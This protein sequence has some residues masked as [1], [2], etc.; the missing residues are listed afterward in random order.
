MR[1][2]LSR[3]CYDK[4]WRCPGWAGGG[5]K[6]AYVQRCPGGSTTLIDAEG[7]R[8]KWGFQRHD[9]G[10]IVLPLMTRWLDP[11]WWLWGPLWGLNMKIWQW[12][13]NWRKR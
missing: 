5:S 2:R 4:P 3:P 7:W 13:N 8:W 9:C 12:R 11:T 10:V 6:L 1:W